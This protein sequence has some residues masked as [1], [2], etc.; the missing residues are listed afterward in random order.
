MTKVLYLT[1]T[2]SV[3]ICYAHHSDKTLK[4]QNILIINR[5]KIKNVCEEKHRFT[6]STAK[7]V[8]KSSFCCFVILRLKMSTLKYFLYLEKWK[9]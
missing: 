6:F 4:N 1:D 3:P 8:L 2:Y 5:S 9:Q 7:Q